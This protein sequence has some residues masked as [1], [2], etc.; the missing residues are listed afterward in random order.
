MGVGTA[1]AFGAAAERPRR[2]A[3]ARI[4]IELAIAHAGHLVAARQAGQADAGKADG[5]KGKKQTTH[6]WV[7]FVICRL[8]FQNGVRTF[9]LKPQDWTAGQAKRPGEN[10]VK[11]LTIIVCGGSVP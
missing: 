4:A 2:A 5:D 9:L 1:A 11:L 6:V 8:R 7:P 3:G 10:A